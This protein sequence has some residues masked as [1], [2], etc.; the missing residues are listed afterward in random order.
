MSAVHQ[1]SINHQVA[2]PHNLDFLAGLP[3]P[4]ILDIF[5]S[6]YGGAGPKNGSGSTQKQGRRAAPA[7]LLSGS[8]ALLQSPPQ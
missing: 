7:T 2:Q 3:K 5:G 6:G 1:K 8:V 4:P